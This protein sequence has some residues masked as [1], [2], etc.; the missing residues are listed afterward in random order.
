MPLDLTPIVIAGATGSG[1]SLLALDIASKLGGEIVCA[2]SRQIYKNMNIG[3]SGPS[4]LDYCRI[5]H[6]GFEKL[7]PNEI[8]SAGQFVLDTDIAVRNIKAR[9]KI[10]ILVGGTGLYLRAWR[11]GIDTF[12]PTNQCIRHQ[13]EEEDPLILYDRLMILD[14]ITATQIDRNDIM[15]IRRALEICIITGRRV[16][17]LVKINLNQIPRVNAYWFLKIC[18]REELENNLMIRVEKMFNLGFVDEALKLNG[19]VPTT[20]YK[21]VLEYAR[22][23]ISKKEAI[24]KIFIK[25]RQYAKKQITWFKKES[26][27]R[28]DFV[29]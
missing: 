5:P 19:Q 4:L 25:H 11:F 1:K 3:T 14:T 24:E 6:H 27:W 26:W 12:F 20:G 21:E 13:L 8:Y 17:D 7:E 28:R 18:P 16:S 9:K 23:I 2:D 10:P 22:N 15:R 29:L